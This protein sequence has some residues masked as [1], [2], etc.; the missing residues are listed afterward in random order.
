MQSRN[1]TLLNM[2]LFSSLPQG[3]YT[4]HNKNEENR[5]SVPRWEIICYYYIFTIQKNPGEEKKISVIMENA[6]EMYCWVIMTFYP[7]MT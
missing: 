4:Y 7:F 3:S 6:I 2:S 5:S 1:G